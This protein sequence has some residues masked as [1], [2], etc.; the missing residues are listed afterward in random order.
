MISRREMLKL[1]S[2]AGA[3]LIT[4]GFTRQ[5]PVTNLFSEK[6]LTR[7]IPSSGEL[8]P[9]VGLGTWQTFDVGKSESDRAPLK[10]VL[11]LMKEK[12]GKVIDSSPMYGRSEEVVGDLAA[13][14]KIQD[15][16]FYA[17]KVWTSGKEQGINQMNESFKKMKRNV[18]DLMQIHNLVDW[19]TH[20]K[21][22]KEWKEGGKIRYIGITHYTVSSY[23]QLEEII[24]KEKIDFV[25]FNYSIDVRDAEKRLLPAAKDNGTAVIINRPYGG[26]NLFSKVRGKEI[27]EWAKEFDI[28]SWG[29]FFLKFIL[30]NDAVT[31]AIPG[32]SR[33]NHLVDN[34]MAGYGELPDTKMR[35]RMA[36]FV[37]E[38]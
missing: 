29:Q 19:K 31:C 3:G 6:M 24:K 21:T 25:Q 20:L 27:P 17:T 36:E 15:S 34:M 18:M 23:P 22:L 28:S 38:L 14:L 32:T 8:L 11:M 2:L 4:N 37:R 30:S 7:K 13:E 10:E 5:L 35:E 12:G 26:G 16:F 9:V 1:L 33:P